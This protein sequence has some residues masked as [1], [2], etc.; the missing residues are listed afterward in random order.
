[1]VV[2]HQLVE[3][4]SL[5]F[6]CSPHSQL[7]CGPGDR[8]SEAA[9]EIRQNR[10]RVIAFYCFNSS[11]STVSRFAILILEQFAATAPRGAQ[12]VIAVECLGI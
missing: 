11:V 4:V 9:A 5:S 2:V 7:C 10:V 12:H 8:Q 1:M 3:Q 6:I